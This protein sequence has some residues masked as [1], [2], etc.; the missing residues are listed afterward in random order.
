MNGVIR[1]GDPLVT[2][3]KVSTASGPEFMGK[4]VM[5]QGDL[6]SCTVPGHGINPVNECCTAWTVDGKGVVVDRC[7]ASC[8]CVIT[9]TL[10]NAGTEL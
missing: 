8:G 1:M 5:L 10:P 3:G 4:K 7:K 2:G 6:V 9:S